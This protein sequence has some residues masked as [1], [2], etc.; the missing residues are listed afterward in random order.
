M[1]V[2]FRCPSCGNNLAPLRLPCPGCGFTGATS[3]RKTRWKVWACLALVW[4]LYLGYTV[5]QLRYE[6]NELGPLGEI[7]HEIQMR[8][9]HELRR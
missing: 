6:R 9:E 3:R 7:L 2:V 5:L 4:V 8:R 1:K